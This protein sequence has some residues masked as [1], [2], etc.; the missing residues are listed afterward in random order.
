MAMEAWFDGYRS[1]F[2]NWFDE[3]GKDLEAAKKLVPLE[4]ILDL[5]DPTMDPKLAVKEYEKAD[6][7]IKKWVST[8]RRLID[9]VYDKIKKVFG[10]NISDPRT[11]AL[12]LY[13]NY[14]IDRNIDAFYEELAAMTDQLEEC[15]GRLQTEER[16]RGYAQ[17]VSDTERMSRMSVNNSTP[18][19]RNRT[20]NDV[21]EN[22]TLNGEMRRNLY[23]TDVQ[24]TTDNRQ[25]GHA[26]A[27]EE[28]NERG[29]AIGTPTPSVIFHGDESGR[30]KCIQHDGTMYFPKIMNQNEIQIGFNSDQN[31]TGNMI[32]ERVQ[33]KEA[34]KEDNRYDETC[35][36][37]YKVP[38]EGLRPWSRS[39]NNENRLQEP[40]MNGTNLDYPRTSTRLGADHGFQSGEDRFREESRSGS[41]SG[42]RQRRFN[43]ERIRLN[44]F[45][46][47]IPSEYPNFRKI[48]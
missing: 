29:I 46:G 22:G 48:F 28:Q 14:Q 25:T 34:T 9:S 35:F 24:M 27:R 8:G 6:R 38:A 47:K 33:I 30:T 20:P 42:R 21:Q 40:R 11:A 43:L 19:T 17:S 13:G 12:N 15:I 39:S 26:V 36:Q 10:A 45:S 16:K 31:R 23:P 41:D 7:N 1:H 32:E 5:D 37:I 3:G 4:R 44:K 2:N 18:V